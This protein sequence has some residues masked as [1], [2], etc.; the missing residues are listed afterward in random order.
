[1]ADIPW[2]ELMDAA[3][4]SDF[5]PIPQGDYDLKIVETEA[6]KSSTDKPMWK[7]TTVVMNGPHEGR[8]VWTQQTL[9]MDNPDALNVFFRQMAAAGLTGEFFKTKPSNQKIADALLGRSFRGKVT[10]REWQGVPRNNIKQ[11]NP[12]GAG[13]GA[14][15]G[16]PPPPGAGMASGGPPPPPASSTAP[17]AASSP[18]PPPSSTPPPAAAPSAPA[19]SAPP[20]P[21]P[22][23][24]EPPAS[25]TN[26]AATSEPESVPA[27]GR[28]P[29]IVEER[30][31][32]ST[33]P[34][35]F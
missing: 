6:T 13:M 30:K 3:Q 17:P 14:A 11:W 31:T 22:S 35:P 34:P 26:G 24:P 33:E 27:G 15:G 2:D 12:M 1:M 32:G 18:P 7:I 23:A 21:P 4:D 20:P 19:A 10:I 28:D 8:K 9:T 29:W 25:S 5:A 16:P